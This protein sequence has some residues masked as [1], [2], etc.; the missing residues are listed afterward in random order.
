MKSDAS[1]RAGGR[2]GLVQPLDVVLNDISDIPTDQPPLPEELGDLTR[3]L[4][5]WLGRLVSIAAAAGSTDTQNVEIVR[6]PDAPCNVR[7]LAASYDHAL[8]NLRRRTRIALAL[9]E[10]PAETS[11]M[12]EIA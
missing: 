5:R 7:E 3:R 11:T 8:G 9:M 10:R 2:L 6:R 4:R 1:V 12:K